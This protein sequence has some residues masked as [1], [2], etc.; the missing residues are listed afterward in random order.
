MSE[1][2]GLGGRESSV[3]SRSDRL[4][5]EE[6]PRPVDAGED[7]LGYISK[8]LWE[9][10]QK[11]AYKNLGLSRE[12]SITRVADREKGTK[13]IKKPTRVRKPSPGRGKPSEYPKQKRRPS[14][15]R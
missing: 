10:H 1:R 4:Y 15:E 13:L 5:I 11:K 2:F 9:G 14:S 7:R 3:Q 8:N 6:R 12:S